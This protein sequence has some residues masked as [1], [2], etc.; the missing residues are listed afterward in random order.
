MKVYMDY[1]ATTPVDPRVAEMA[2]PYLKKDS[3][4]NPSSFHLYG[5]EA[6]GAINQAREEVA[7]SLGASEE[8][9]IFTGSGSEGDNHA[10]KGAFFSMNH[11][12]NHIITS[13]IEHPAVLGTC[14]WLEKTENAAVTYL[15]PDD[16]GHIRPEQ[17]EHAITDKTV[18]VTIMAANNEIGTIYPI[19]EIAAICRKQGVLS[20]TDA[21][22]AFG[23]IP[24]NA[25]ELGVDL[26]SIAGH[27]IYAPK[28]IGALYVRDGVKMDNFIHGGHQ[29]WGKRA[30]T[31]NVLG[32]V[33]LGEACRIIHE[34]LPEEMVEIARLR[35]KLETG[36]LDAI[37]YTSVNGDK[38][39]RVPNTTNIS[40]E[41]IEGEALLLALDMVEIA[42]S[43]GSACATGSDD[44]SHVLRAIGLKPETARSSLRFSIGRFTNEQ[45]VDY[46]LEKLPAIVEKL[47]AMS[48]V[49]PKK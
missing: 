22:Q 20:H 19:R 47:R 5:R 10:I 13:A 7:R 39:L 46:V 48:P 26:L 23:K 40:F 17:V 25:K 31:E 37:P 14:D 9:I 34:N 11:G 30:G 27:K 4:G 49:Y 8:E 45:D 3:F 38:E 28:G 32:I 1:N 24:I 6:K 15:Q 29:E 18:L 12:K 44:P 33:A 43:S 21:V 16:K 36:I 42:V 35:D 41:Y 2:I